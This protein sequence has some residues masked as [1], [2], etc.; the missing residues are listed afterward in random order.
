MD[1][2]LSTNFE[3]IHANPI[4]VPQ[5]TTEMVN[6]LSTIFIVFVAL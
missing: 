4:T 1:I 5:L 3:L 6:L 2:G